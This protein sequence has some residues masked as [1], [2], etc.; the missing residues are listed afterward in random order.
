MTRSEWACLELGFQ[1][2]MTEDE[3]RQQR[4]LDFI[5]IVVDS[6][7]RCT[8]PIRGGNV[9]VLQSLNIFKEYYVQ[10][11]VLLFQGRGQTEC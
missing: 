7:L 4:C 9:N 5:L 6:V 1:G 2:D 10:A 11:E 3:N 8:S